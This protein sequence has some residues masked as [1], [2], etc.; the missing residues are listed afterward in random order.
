MPVHLPS[1]IRSAVI[2]YWLR[3]HSR[4]EIASQFGISTGVVTNIVN[5]WRNNLGS[6]IVDDLRELSLSLKKAGIT[7]TE[8][9]IGFRVVKMMQKFGVDE[10]QFEYFMIEVYNKC[11]V[12][13]IGPNQLGE[14]L[15]EIVNLSNVVFP[16][17]IPNYI[18][19]KKREIETLNEQMEN[20]Q[21]TIS[22]LNSKKIKE[23]EELK[24]LI[25]TSNISR[26]AIKWY[27]EI[28]K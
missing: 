22:E 28:I 26:E 3:G 17:Q 7:S 12:L 20:M 15:T 25:E 21:K 18:N 27:K 2:R 1:E 13:E 24:S 8:C 19:S 23:E 11:Q 9:A 14:Y 10:D 6:Y 16:S 5:E 4:D